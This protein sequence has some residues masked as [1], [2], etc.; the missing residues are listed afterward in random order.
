MT[1][2]RSS[3]EPAVR[4]AIPPYRLAMLRIQYVP[5]LHLGIEVHARERTGAEH[6]GE[7]SQ[8]HVIKDDPA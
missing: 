7:L 6:A 8:H 5:D 3:L 2:T 4:E 1:R